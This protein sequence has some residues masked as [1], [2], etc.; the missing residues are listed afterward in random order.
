VAGT[1][2]ISDHRN[3]MNPLRAR[4]RRHVLIDAIAEDVEANADV[5]AV[6]NGELTNETSELSR[7]R[8]IISR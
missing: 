6:G 3:A 8:V 5:V 2:Q 7:R 1:P 4:I